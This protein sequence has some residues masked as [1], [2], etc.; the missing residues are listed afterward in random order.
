MHDVQFNKVNKVL[1]WAFERAFHVGNECR[2][3]C[4]GEI[5]SQ[6]LFILLL[7]YFKNTSHNM[8]ANV[9]VFTDVTRIYDKH[10]KATQILCTYLQLYTALTRVS[11]A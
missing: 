8:I 2:L 1:I 3:H 7:L 5:N 11:L 6:L 10:S 4:S 9:G